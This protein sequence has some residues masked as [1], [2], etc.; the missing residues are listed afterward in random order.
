MN[1]NAGFEDIICEWV[2]V[3]ELIKSIKNVRKRKIIAYKA[4]GYANWEIAKKLGIAERNIDKHIH[5][6]KKYLSNRVGKSA[7]KTL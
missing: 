2:D 4:M 7:G 1:Y 3:L 5:T 6:I